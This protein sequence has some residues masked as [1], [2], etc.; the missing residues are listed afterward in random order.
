MCIRDRGGLFAVVHQNGGDIYFYDIEKNGLKSRLIKTLSTRASESSG[1]EFDSSEGKLY[2]WHNVG[3]NSIE[4]VK[5][6]VA[7]DG[8]LELIK[9]IDGPKTGNIEGIAVGSVGEGEHYLFFTDDDN[10][11]GYALFW[12]DS[13]TL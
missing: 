2:I 4:I 12:Y 13:L 7:E 11:D 6:S 5:P 10:Q 3:S 8:M 9:H 1:L